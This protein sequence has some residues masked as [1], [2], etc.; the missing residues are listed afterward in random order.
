MFP[1]LYLDCL[2]FLGNIF[3]NDLYELTEMLLIKFVLHTELEVSTNVTDDRRKIIRKSFLTE[4]WIYTES[5][6]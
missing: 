5:W 3:V 1:P 4:S 6:T 2:S